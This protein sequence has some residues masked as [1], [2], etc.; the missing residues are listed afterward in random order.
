VAAP[1]VLVVAVLLASCSSTP[2]NQSLPA[3]TRR[4]ATTAPPETS[5]TT[6][7]PPEPS[8]VPFD[9]TPLRL[10]YDQPAPGFVN[11]GDAKLLI[12]V[13]S[14][15]GGIVS[16]ATGP[17]PGDGQAVRFPP[18]DPTAPAP[19]AVLEV[20]SVDT[21]DRLNPGASRFEYGTDFTLDATSVDLDPKSIDDGDNLMQ[22]G[23]YNEVTQYKLEI[24]H[25]QPICRVKGR[26]GE[27]TV[28]AGIKVEPDRWYRARCLRDADRVTVSVSSWKPDGSLTTRTFSKVGTTG[29]MT[30]AASSVPLSLGGKLEAN[31]V[32]GDADQ[33]NG[34][35][36]NTYVSL[37]GPPS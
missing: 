20:I 13:L 22:R 2:S 10:S 24:D 33:F 14:A 28:F 25:R 3:S 16:T 26:E 15:D 34:R 30:P 21:R 31:R 5:T 35:L 17:T 23:R 32:A 1:V 6:P 11:G 29:D 37:D 4:H 18:T 27:L 36:D 9:Q 8:P 7:A 19:R 12:T